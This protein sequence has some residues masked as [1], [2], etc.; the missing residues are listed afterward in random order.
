MCTNFTPTANDMLVQFGVERAP[1]DYKAEAYPGYDAPIVINIMRRAGAAGAAADIERESESEANTKRECIPARFGLIPPNIFAEDVKSFVRKYHTNN[2]RSETV[3][4]RRSFR[5]AWKKQQVCLIPVSCFYEPNWET[6]KAV[7]WKIWLKDTKDFA[8]AGLWEQ[9]KRGE[10]S[11]HSFTM[12]TVNADDH[13]VM[14][15]FHRH[16]E[17]RRMPVILH[18]D[19]YD[20]WLRATP[21][22]AFRMC[23]RYP[24]AL[25][26]SAPAPKLGAKA[27]IELPPEGEAESG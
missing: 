24:A 19:D 16:G 10:E 27:K 13:A 5:N 6:A 8:I 3:A 12:L 18:P 23:Q 20:R 25:M 7:R 1:F 11:F 22:E 4:E 14:R 21:E 17:E 9:W 2:A 15:H 26:D